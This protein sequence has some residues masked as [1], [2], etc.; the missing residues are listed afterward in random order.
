MLYTNGSRCP[1]VF[2]RHKWRFL[3]QAGNGG[4]ILVVSAGL[5][6]WSSV[7]D[8]CAASVS[9]FGKIRVLTTEH[10]FKLLEL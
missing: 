7:F 5:G 3:L 10:P 9:T 6:I 2:S 4:A 1:G 8:G